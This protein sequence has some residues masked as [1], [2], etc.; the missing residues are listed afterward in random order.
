[1]IPTRKLRR[2]RPTLIHV[3]L[4]LAILLLLVFLIS[5]VAFCDTVIGCRI[6]NI[7]RIYIILV[8]LM[9]NGVEA[10]WMYISLVK[11]YAAHASHFVLKAGL[12]AWGASK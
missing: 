8:S 2:G 12:I 9:W 11:V 4:C 5:S 3:N 6:A 7:I 1:M 10:V